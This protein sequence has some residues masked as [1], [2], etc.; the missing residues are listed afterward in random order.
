MA[1]D[2][3]SVVATIKADITDF[4]RGIGVAKNEVS[5][6]GH[7]V[8]NTSTLLK[9]GMVAAAGAAAAGIGF[10]A[11]A[12]IS[13]AGDFQ[14]TAIAFETMLGG[15]EKGAQKAQKLL[16]D[17]QEF[18]KK[19]PF[20]LVELQEGSKRLLAY[21]VE[22]EK[23]IDTMRV[24]GNITSGVGRDKLPQLILAF[25]QVK[26]AGRLTGAELRQFAE[27]GVPLLDAL[28]KQFGVT[29]G[30][31]QEM[32]S[33]GDVGFSDVEQALTGMTTEGGKFF[34]L[35][36]RQSGTLQGQISNL[37]DVWGQLL[38]TL[39]TL[40]IP[41]ATQVVQALNNF[42]VPILNAIKGLTDWQTALR[43]T[44]EQMAFLQMA[45]DEF[46]RFMDETFMPAVEVVAAWFAARWTGIS[47]IF[48]G[49]WTMMVG[50][51]QVGWSI[52][53]GIIKI[54]LEILAGDWNGAWTALKEMVNGILQGVM[55]SMQGFVQMVIGWGQTLFEKLTE[56]FERAWNSIKETMKKIKD[57]L[58]FTKRH[59]P[60]VLDIVNRGVDL[61]NNAMENL[62]MGGVGT[63]PVAH[64]MAPVGVGA[65]GTIANITIDLNG[66]I[67]SDELGASRMG[68]L[69]GDS[70]I[71]K[72]GLTL[73]H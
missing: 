43:L 4:K 2:V 26:A 20:N 66:A 15:G 46:N 36:N 52:I 24:L 10:L 8:G 67:I 16:G 62:D 60:S 50:A 57:A 12:S 35:M 31:I 33:A 69:I 55:T 53:Y 59:S 72:M 48:G 61:V 47:N 14:Q 34:D 22:S 32:I 71:K 23:L 28:A 54:G 11:K 68:E 73:R 7:T 39:G 56:P 9:V 65:S 6:L 45:M 30:E 27:A 49:I 38:V 40:F 13:A 51:V 21:N 3:G 1:F 42:L 63:I 70:I 25:G 64:Q 29:A 44:D 37:Q 41:L 58:D 17:L 19:T 18:A 5:D